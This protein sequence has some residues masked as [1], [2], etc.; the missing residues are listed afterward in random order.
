MDPNMFGTNAQWARILKF[1]LLAFIL[2]VCFAFGL[3]A[4]LF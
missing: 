1:A 2:I 4:W 3:G